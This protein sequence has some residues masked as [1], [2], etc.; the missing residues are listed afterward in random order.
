MKK[1]NLINQEPFLCVPCCFEMIFKRRGIEIDKSQIELA[2]MMDF[3]LDPNVNTESWKY[4]EDNG[5][6][7]RKGNHSE[8][9][10]GCKFKDFGKQIATPLNI[11]LKEIYFTSS[12]FT[13]ELGEDN[14]MLFARQCE[15][16]LKANTDVLMAINYKVIIDN[17]NCDIH[18]VDYWGHALLLEYIDDKFN[19]HVVVPETKEKGGTKRMVIPLEVMYKSFYSHRRGFV[20]SYYSFFCIWKI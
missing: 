1:Y 15:I 17:G 20:S 16:Y 12:M 9:D 8:G 14:Y 18:E 13:R 2:F 6:I 10:T 3:S 7:V 5:I 11:P 4:Y 19:F